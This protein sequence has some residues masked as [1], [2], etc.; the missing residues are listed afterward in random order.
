M[1]GAGA[2]QQTSTTTLATWQIT[3][4]RD[5]NSSFR[6]SAAGR[7]STLDVERD[8]VGAFDGTSIAHLERYA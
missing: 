3:T 1:Q 8:E 5:R 7:W 6:S 4:T 2:Q